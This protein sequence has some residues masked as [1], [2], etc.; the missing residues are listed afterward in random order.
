M[1]RGPAWTEIEDSTL[2]R[3]HAEGMGWADI[4]VVIGRPRQSCHSRWQLLNPDPV[5]TCRTC[6]ETKPVS[7]F[8]KRKGFL[9]SSHLSHILVC[10]ACISRQAREASAVSHGKRPVWRPAGPAMWDEAP[11][12]PLSVSDYKTRLLARVREERA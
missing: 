6:G 4:G 9:E 7:D 1:S 10:K 2:L 12:G 8:H 3:L 11:P 5:H